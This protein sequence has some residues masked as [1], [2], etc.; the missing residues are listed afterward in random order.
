MVKL[1]KDGKTMAQIAEQF[2]CSV[3]KVEV[4]FEQEGVEKRRPGSAA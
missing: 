4:I 2:Q 1:Y 3:P